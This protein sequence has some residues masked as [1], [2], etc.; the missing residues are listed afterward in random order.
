MLGHAINAFGRCK[1]A[2][3]LI[4]PI[5]PILKSPI[6]N[7]KS[8]SAPLREDSLV[9]KP[10]FVKRTHFSM[11]NSINQK[12]M[13]SNNPAIKIKPIQGSPRPIPPP[14]QV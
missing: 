6:S 4:R 13:R 5:R 12:D 9:K 11:Q 2:V 8:T 14:S 7:L 1:S 10:F 3:G